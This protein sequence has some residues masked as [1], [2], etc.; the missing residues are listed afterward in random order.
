ML[1]KSFLHP[2]TFNC[3]L[4]VTPGEEAHFNLS[5]R[6]ASHNFCKKNE[7]DTHDRYVKVRIVKETGRFNIPDAWWRENPWMDQTFW[8]YQTPVKMFHKDSAWQ[9][10]LC[11]ALE[12]MECERVRLYE[13]ERYGRSKFA[14]GDS[15]IVPCDCCVQCWDEMLAG[16]SEHVRER[17]KLEDVKD[18][19]V[20]DERLSTE[21]KI[22]NFKTNEDRENDAILEE[23]AAKIEKKI[24]DIEQDPRWNK[25]FDSDALLQ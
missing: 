6:L 23:K 21:Q 8:A 5:F 13:L 9:P 17:P 24:A 7:I 15:L 12:M 3:W 19:D 14:A 20:Q 1:I 11:Y 10:Y 25:E 22:V 2:D 16:V 18:P 4:S